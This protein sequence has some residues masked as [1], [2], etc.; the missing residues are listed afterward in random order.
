VVRLWLSRSEPSRNDRLSVTM[1]PES[2]WASRSSLGPDDSGGRAA[3]RRSSSRDVTVSV[4]PESSPVAAV[5]LGDVSS[6]SSAV[7]QMPEVTTTDSKVLFPA[8]DWAGTFE[9]HRR[10]RVVLSAIGLAGLTVAVALGLALRPS[11]RGATRAH[12]TEVSAAG[13]TPALPVV[14]ADK[15]PAGASSVA[16]PSPAD[17]SSSARAPDGAPT[18]LAS[19]PRPAGGPLPAKPRSGRPA[20]ALTSDDLPDD[21]SRNPYR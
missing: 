11:P 8:S 5:K 3:L 2:R 21:L 13:T 9:P 4:P 14:P 1:G 18:P 20:P 15:G 16:P 6:V 7:L 19:A 17:P 10:K 12:A